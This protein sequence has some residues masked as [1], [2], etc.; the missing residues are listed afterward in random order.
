MVTLYRALNRR[1]A[2][3]AVSGMGTGRAR[4][5]DLMWEL[6]Q[7][8]EIRQLNLQLLVLKWEPQVS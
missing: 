6:F 5:D 3:W 8:E 7:V 2:A 1:D 4:T